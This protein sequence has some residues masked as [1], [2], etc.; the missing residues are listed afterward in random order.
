MCIYGLKVLDFTNIDWLTHSKDAEGLWDLTQHYLGWEFYRQSPWHFP[1]GLA[2]GLYSSPVS[3]VYTDSIPL[4]AFICKILSPILPET[5]QYFGIFGLMTYMLMGGFGAL[6]IAR[7]NSNPLYS[8]ISAIIMSISPVLTKR[9]FYHTALSAHFLILMAIALWIYRDDCFIQDKAH[10]RSHLKASYVILWA[11][12]VASSALINAY[13]TPMV[14]GIL[15]LSCLQDLISSGWYKTSIIRSL[16][17][18]IPTLIFTGL[19]AYAFGFFYGDVAPST[20]GLDNLSF[21]M[22]QLINPVNYLCHISNY[23]YNFTEQSYSAFLPGLSTMSGWQEEGF[24]YLGLGMIIALALMLVLVMIYHL[25]P[26]TSSLTALV[27]DGYSWV[28]SVLVGLIV[29]TFLALSPVATAGNKIVYSINYPEGIYKI[30]SVFRSC[31]RFIRPVYYGIL[32]IVLSTYAKI[33]ARIDLEGHKSK[34][35]L[36]RIILSVLLICICLIQVAD[37]YPSLKYKQDAYNN[38]SSDYRSPLV[39]P[40][41][42]ELGTKADEIMFYTPSVYGMECNPELS[43][44]FEEYALEYD[45]SLNITYMSRDMSSFADEKTLRHFADREK[46]LE[47]ESIIYIFYD[48]S[49][50]PPASKSHLNYYMIDGY[51][52]GT[53]LILENASRYNP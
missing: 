21:N 20:V 45:L 18:C 17:C 8:S 5:F 4:F 52:I 16:T 11:L 2:D 36:A 26:E 32:V 39:D 41:W 29:F 51:V 35:K 49:D 48:I 46:G 24:A 42:N 1:L 28:I 19:I 23:N 44:I 10:N 22:N 30:L 33:A 6:I 34:H 12:V 15:L 7:Y 37:I 14:L 9:M 47:D 50:I 25:K 40:A 31:G 53:D 43:C 13:Y 3:I 27:S 38:I